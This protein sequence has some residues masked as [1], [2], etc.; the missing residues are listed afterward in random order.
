MIQHN[1][2]YQTTFLYRTRA[3][4]MFLQEAPLTICN[5]FHSENPK[6]QN[7]NPEALN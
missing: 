6:I 1:S 5:S 7:K 3:S 2:Q 4:A